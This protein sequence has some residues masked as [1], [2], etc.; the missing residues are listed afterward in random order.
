MPSL[1]SKKI[2]IHFTDQ[3]PSF[4]L[5]LIYTVCWQAAVYKACK[6]LNSELVT[7]KSCEN[8]DQLVPDLW[9]ELLMFL[10]KPRSY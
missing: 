1:L 6:E 2:L 4:L 10:D 7:D 9:V 8:F 3:C 5:A